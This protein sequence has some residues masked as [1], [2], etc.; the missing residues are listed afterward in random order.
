MKSFE[1]GDVVQCEYS[2]KPRLMVVE[3]LISS[4]DSPSS[5]DGIKGETPDGF[6]HFHVSRMEWPTIVCSALLED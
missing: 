3:E 1:I 5:E 6:R 4:E 2:G